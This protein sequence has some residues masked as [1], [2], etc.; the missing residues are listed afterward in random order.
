MTGYGRGESSGSKNKFTVE[1]RSVNGKSLDLSFRA[2]YNCRSVEQD[3]RAMA[4]KTLLRGKSELIVGVENL[5]PAAVS[6]I[7][8]EMFKGYYREIVALSRE[9]GCEIEAEP[10]MSTILR[11]PEV[12][13]AGEKESFSS[14]DLHALTAATAA[15]L[16]AIDDFR[17]KEGAVL[18]ADM[19]QRT[20]T[21]ADL[22]KQVEP[23]ESE[24]IESVKNRLNDNLAKAQINVDSNR[25]ESEIIYYLEKF[26]VT[27]EKVRLKQ[28]IK[29][30]HE[31][32]SNGGDAGRKL[33][34]IAQEMGREINTLGSKA[35]HHEIQRIVVQMK[36]ELEKIKEQLLNL[37]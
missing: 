19:L 27:E 13:A 25:F 33:G 11:L 37:L 18:I 23:Y 36:D 20:A 3:L 10:I 28:H 24:R 5:T 7:N 29:Y 30:F 22:L 35:N 34:F 14:E 1:V 21:I 32:A 2:P 17:A 4:T 8:H 31:V 26:D 16:Q 12:V 15:A 6:A 9:V